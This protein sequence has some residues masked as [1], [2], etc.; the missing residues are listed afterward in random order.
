MVNGSLVPQKKKRIRIPTDDK[1]FYG[2]IL[3]LITVLFLAVLYPILFIISAS[4]SSA[5]AIYA[6]RVH[7]FPVD[8]SLVGYDLVFSNREVWHSYGNTIFYTVVGTLINVSLI[9]IAAYPLSRHDLPGRN[10]FM[11]F[12]TFTMFFSGGMIPTFLVVRNLGMMDSFWSL[13]LPGAL[14]VY[15]MIVART[16]IQSSIPKELLEAA[17]IDGCSDAMYFFRIVLP[18]SSAILAV[19]ALFMA[20]SHWNA[21]FDAMLYLNTRSKVPLQLVLRDILVTS[22]YAASTADMSSMDPE[23]LVALQ[24]MADV[25]KYALIVFSS[26]PIMLFYPFAQKYFIKGVMIGSIKG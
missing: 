16:F 25:M 26:L 20:V 24:R 8:F 10:L 19:T 18:L 17:Q 2:M 9:M 3:F 22:Q 7:I 23:M 11:A 14:S 6:G 5:D 21:Y 15:Y 4:F 12:F 13:I 1:V